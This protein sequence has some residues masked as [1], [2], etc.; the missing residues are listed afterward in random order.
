MLSVFK[1]H[2]IYTWFFWKIG[3]A[4]KRQESKRMDAKRGEWTRKNSYEK[5]FDRVWN[6]EW[7]EGIHHRDT[8][9]QSMPD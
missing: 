9:A 5:A 3:V 2:A 1:L 7:G 6:R 4:K 8:E